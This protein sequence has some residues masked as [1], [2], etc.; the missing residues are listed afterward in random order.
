M[1]L[2]QRGPQLAGGQRGTGIEISM[3]APAKSSTQGDE[4]VA[5]SA[6]CCSE[7]ALRP[8]IEVAIGTSGLSVIISVGRWSH[9][10]GGRNNSSRAVTRFKLQRGLGRGIFASL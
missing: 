8:P 7:T 10:T 4:S 5:L 2:A 1:R 6:P 9:R 3:L